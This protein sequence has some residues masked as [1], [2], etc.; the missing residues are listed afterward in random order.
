[1]GG[2]KIQRI[3]IPNPKIKINREYFLKKVLGKVTILKKSM[4]TRKKKEKK[5][6]VTQFY[7]KPIY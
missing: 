3:L 1:M 6:I 7:Y 2:K 4:V 5:I